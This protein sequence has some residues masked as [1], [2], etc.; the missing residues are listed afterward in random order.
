MTVASPKQSPAADGGDALVRETRSGQR[1]RQVAV[2]GGLA[3]L[4]AVA[5]GAYSLTVG[6][7]SNRTFARG[8]LSPA[9][10]AACSGPVTP[11]VSAPVG[12]N[13][14]RALGNV[15]WLSTVF[16]GASAPTQVWIE[17]MRSTTVPR[18]VLR[19][20]RCSDGRLLHFWFQ[21]PGPG[22][23]SGSSEAV[24]YQAQQQAARAAARLERGGGSLTATLQPRALSQ[25]LLCGTQPPTVGRPRAVTPCATDGA[26]M[27]SSPG[28]WV[29]QA[30]NGGR[31]VG[32]AVFD[33]HT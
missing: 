8:P 7:D 33:L 13:N 24:A 28:K 29:V 2:A 30:E 20:W 6:T 15:L 1:R 16:Y 25:G 12:L 9:A 4:A 32:T 10:A 14:A 3:L 22:D 27:F 11:V 23:Y 21:P 19:G 31:V 18:V 26:F 5:F 17:A